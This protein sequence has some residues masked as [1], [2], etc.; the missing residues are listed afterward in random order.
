MATCNWCD[1]EL[2][3]GNFVTFG[4]TTMHKECEA[5]YYAECQAYDAQ[6]A[7]YED[8]HSMYD[9]DPNVYHGDYSEM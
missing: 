2:T 4:G 6:C 9:D 3:N 1:K 7:M 8:C 5:E